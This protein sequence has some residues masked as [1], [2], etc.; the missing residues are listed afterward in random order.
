MSPSGEKRCLTPCTLSLDRSGGATVVAVGK[1]GFVTLHESVLPDVDQ[2][3]HLTLQAVEARGH[4]A[5]SRREPLPR[6][7]SPSAS[8]VFQRFD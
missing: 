1:A 7:A 3:I 8:S 4:S 5:P 6:S 2:R